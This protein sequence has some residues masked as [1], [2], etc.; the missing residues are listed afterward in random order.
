MNVNSLIKKAASYVL[1]AMVLV[2]TVIA[3][4]AIWDV[5]VLEDVIRK[6]LTSL[7]VVF[8]ASVVI[9]FIFSVIIRSNGKQN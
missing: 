8:V 7:F 4:L 6:I 5:I 1:V 3:V 9:L 2:I